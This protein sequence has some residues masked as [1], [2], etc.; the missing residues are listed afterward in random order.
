MLTY[1]LPFHAIFNLVLLS[2]VRGTQSSA[3]H[4][5]SSLEIG[6]RDKGQELRKFMARFPWNVVKYLHLVKYSEKLGNQFSN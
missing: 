3:P 4:E 6:S 1:F 5:Q 2:C